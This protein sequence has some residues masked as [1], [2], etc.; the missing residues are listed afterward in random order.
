MPGLD[1]Q[2]VGEI[3]WRASVDNII[4]DTRSDFILSPHY[5]AVYLSS[6]DNLIE[7]TKRD[8]SSGTYCP[9]LP[10]TMSVPK[11]NYLTR[12]GSILEPKDR[13]I[14][15]AL[16]DQIIQIIEAEL[17]RTRVFSQIP[18]EDE[19]FLFQPTHIGW[20]EYQ[21]SIGNL[22][23]AS[24][25]V[26]K[27]DISNY[28]ETI[29]QHTLINLLSSSGVR[30]EIFRLLEEQ[31]LAFR[32]RSSVGIIQGI[33]PS[34]VL[35]NFYLSV[36]D[37]EC[38]MRDIPSTRYVDD[39]FVGFR[40]QPTASQQIVTL[41][42]V[43]RR[44]GLSLNPAKTSVLPAD[45]V[46]LQER[47]VDHLFQDAHEAIADEVEQ[48]RR[49]GYGFQGD[50]INEADDN[51]EPD[52]ELEAFR[53][54][55]AYETDDSKLREKIERFC[56]PIL[57]GAGKDI[58][59]DVVFEGLDQRP[60][61][62]RLYSSYLTHFTPSNRDISDRVEAL[63]AQDNFFCDYQ[64]MYMLASIMKCES[65]SRRTVNIA[66]RW[67]ERGS[68]GAET[69]A[70][71]AIFAAKFGQA[72]QKRSVRTRYENEPSEY[73]RAA[74]LYASQFFGA[75]DKRSARRAWGSH[76]EINAMINSAIAD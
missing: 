50:W 20:N 57:R 72:A 30:P 9:R 53:A 33:F 76:S 19:Q 16:T 14:Y 67:L 55:L 25:V 11:G 62:T 42:E 29:P 36:F 37:N 41:I 48:L 32:E 13:L 15:Q 28:F 71:C 34:D 56:L 40:D 1:K 49:S 51:E 23:E 64:R 17:D 43:V 18:S 38:D 45:Q 2:I 46:I 22:C 10:I 39:I 54:L 63:I 3:D 70:L 73:V 27:T 26:L 52:I 8:L 12:P 31:L 65:V 61:L 5:D 75:A 21:R 59:V 44:N 24:P 68:I 6:S 66:L 58:A 74:I 35:G 47:E 69:R 4:A 7:L 60:H